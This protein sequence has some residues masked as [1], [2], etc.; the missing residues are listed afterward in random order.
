MWSL[1]LTHCRCLAAQ[2]EERGRKIILIAVTHLSEWLKPVLINLWQSL[3]ISF[4]M[5]PNAVEV[6]LPQIN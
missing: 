3:R 1:V 6:D 4:K 2:E 5:F